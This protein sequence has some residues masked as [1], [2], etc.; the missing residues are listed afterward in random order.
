MAPPGFYLLPLRPVSTGLTEDNRLVPIAEDSS[1][2][3][4]ADGA[5]QDHAFE[6][7]AAGNQ[8]SHLVTVRDAGHLLSFIAS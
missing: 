2:E 7:A 8:V 4:P 1:V 3:V 5:R 6:V